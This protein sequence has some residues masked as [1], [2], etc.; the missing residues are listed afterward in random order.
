M[1]ATIKPYRQRALT[2]LLRFARPHFRAAWQWFAPDGVLALLPVGENRAAMIWS[3]PD[4]RA[5]RLQNAPQELLRELDRHAGKYL[6]GAAF[7]DGAALASF[8]L[9]LL[10]RADIAGARIALVGD[11]AHLIHPVAGQG[12]NLGL[13]DARVLAA[14]IAECADCQAALARYRVR[15]RLPIAAAQRLTDL[16]QSA[17]LSAAFA[18]VARAP[19][20][21]KIAAAAANAA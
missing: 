18:A 7:A 6:G 8:P 19:I 21:Q 14:A 3:L 20:L 17:R 15:R 11:S 5:E 12:L 10:R 9:F 2:A 16:F 1:P 13:A 4:A